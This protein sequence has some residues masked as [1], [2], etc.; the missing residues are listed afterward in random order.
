MQAKLFKELISPKKQVKKHHP[1][2]AINPQV[3]RNRNFNII[4][5]FNPYHGKDGRFTSSR[6]AAS[7]TYKPGASTAHSKAIER[8]KAKDADSQKGF[9]GTLYHGSPNKDIKEFDMKR[10]GQ[11]TSSGEK[12]LFFT[13][14]KQMADDFSYERLE[15][16]S[17]FFQE[18]G[19]KGRVY[20]VDVEMKNPLDLRKLNDK[21]IDNILKLDEEGILTKD[22]VQRY[23]NSNHQLLKA[24]L[25]LTS[26]SLKNLGYDGLIANT[27]K[28]GHNS[29]E[30]AVVDS[31]QAK[32]KKSI[33]IKKYNKWHGKDGRFTSGPG[34]GSGAAVNEIEID[35]PQLSPELQGEVS[36]LMGSGMLTMTDMSGQTMS[37][38]VNPDCPQEDI[39][40]LLSQAKTSI[41]VKTSDGEKKDDTPKET[42]RK[43]VAEIED[44]LRGMLDSAAYVDIRGMNEEAA[45]SLMNGTKKAF[46]KCP[47][48]KD[49]ILGVELYSMDDDTYAV[50]D[51]STIFINSKKFAG[52]KEQYEACK[53]HYEKEVKIDFHPKGTTIES[54]V[55]HEM[56]HAV[57]DYLS[58][59]VIDKKSPAN[60]DVSSRIQDKVIN[61]SANNGESVKSQLSGYAEYNHKEFFAEAFSE[62]ISSSNPRA[63]AQSVMK[64]LDTYIKAEQQGVKL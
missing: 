62:A 54:V 24:G 37:L 43:S 8:E 9:K 44:E 59:K 25:T 13:D 5:K 48:L 28:A 17:K 61:S 14:S 2:L 23:A 36:R 56:G 41:R 50:Y 34:G 30:Y 55:I 16:S 12:L 26:E 15:G 31:K 47:F 10:A 7:F 20:E 42:P 39:K 38:Q 40:N 53:Q 33:D 57:D 22:M 64:E 4:N 21:D 6:S 60:K 49:E 45:N 52:T 32:I 35:V 27:G 3:H 51:K 29:I 11:N 46:E 18:R 19:K 58:R 1:Q 63:M